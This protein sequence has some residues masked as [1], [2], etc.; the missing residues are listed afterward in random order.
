[1]SASASART[2][3]SE[4]VPRWSSTGHASARPDRSPALLSAPHS[5]PKAIVI[6]AQAKSIGPTST[7]IHPTAAPPRLAPTRIAAIKSP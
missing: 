6:A 3:A 4:R 7:R 1:M 2:R 5:S